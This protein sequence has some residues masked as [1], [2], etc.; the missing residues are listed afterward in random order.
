MTFKTFK[1]DIK[2]GW[3]SI[4]FGAGKEESACPHHLGGL[5]G[6]LSVQAPSAS[7]RGMV[8]EEAIELFGFPTL[9]KAGIY[10]MGSETNL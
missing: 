2:T 4:R 5:E 3:K 9:S 6:L 1:R 7:G 8:W 10:Q